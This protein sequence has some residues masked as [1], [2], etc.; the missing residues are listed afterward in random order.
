MNKKDS[1]R[2]TTELSSHVK[3][4]EEEAKDE[5]RFKKARGREECRGE[6]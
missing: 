5:D 1:H 4:K 6:I 3:E 2:N